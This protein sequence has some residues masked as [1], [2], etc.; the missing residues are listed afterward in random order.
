ML[1]KDI[2]YKLLTQQKLNNTSGACYIK[3]HLKKYKVY[4]RYKL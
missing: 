2:V 4:D 1:N 3:I